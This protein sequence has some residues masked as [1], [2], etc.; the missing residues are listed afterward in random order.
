MALYSKLYG[1]YKDS[2]VH[3]DYILIRL[4]VGL[5]LQTHM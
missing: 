3:R 4:N 5:Q 2:L 1:W